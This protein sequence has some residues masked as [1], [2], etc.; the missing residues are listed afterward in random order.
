MFSCKKTISSKFSEAKELLSLVTTF[1]EAENNLSDEADD[2]GTHIDTSWQFLPKVA[3]LL[4]EFST[5]LGC[6]HCLMAG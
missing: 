5:R 6:P 2:E 4:P 1:P 3:R